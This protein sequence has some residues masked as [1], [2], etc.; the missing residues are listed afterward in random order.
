MPPDIQKA[1]HEAVK[2]NDVETARRM[3]AAGADVNAPDDEYESS[4][5]KR[6][7]KIKFYALSAFGQKYAHRNAKIG[8]RKG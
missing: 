5:A 3:I 8:K 4:K 2:K 7:H 6:K 1:F